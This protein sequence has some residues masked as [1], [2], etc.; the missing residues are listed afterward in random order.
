VVGGSALISGTLYARLHWKSHVLC[1]AKS[2][3]RTVEPE[4]SNVDTEHQFPW[5][6]FLKL[7]LPDIWYLLGAVLVQL[8]SV[9]FCV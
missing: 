5:K 4:S 8:F 2:W 9:V 1:R 6:E 3:T 7:L